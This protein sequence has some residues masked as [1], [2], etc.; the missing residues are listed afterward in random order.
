M[1]KTRT[2]QVIATNEKQNKL[3]KKLYGNVFGRVLLRT[4]T[5]PA[6]S[7]AAGA[8]M[9]SGAHFEKPLHK[10]WGTTSILYLFLIAAATAT[11]PGRWRTRSHW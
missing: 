9:D 7:R 2:G 10:M 4:L 11:V 5:A 8:F 6:V 1:I 3:L